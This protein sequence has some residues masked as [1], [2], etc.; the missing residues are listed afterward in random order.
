MIGPVSPAS[1]ESPE[2]PLTGAALL[3]AVIEGYIEACLG[4]NCG[5]NI[6]PTEKEA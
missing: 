2:R 6:G 3:G 1:P 5:G 4:N